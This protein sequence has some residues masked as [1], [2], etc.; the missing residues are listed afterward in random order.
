[1]TIYGTGFNYPYG[2]IPDD[3]GVLTGVL[4]SGQPINAEFN[5]DKTYSEDVSIVLAV[6]EP[7]TLVLLT[8]NAVGMSV[9]LRRPC[10]RL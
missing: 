6:Q 2:P 1:M 7:S 5:I 9:F 10:R 3:A 8:T 4:A